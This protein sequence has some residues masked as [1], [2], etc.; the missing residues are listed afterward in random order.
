MIYNPQT[1]DF[2]DVSSWSGNITYE[3]T[4]NDNLISNAFFGIADI[5]NKDYQPPESFNYSYSLGV[6]TFYTIVLGAR[7]GLEYMYG[8]RTNK[9]NSTGNASRIW[10]LL[11]YDF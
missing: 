3:R 5:V 7:L 9:D 11:Y 4:W 8:K 1:K 2:E 6:N 10:M